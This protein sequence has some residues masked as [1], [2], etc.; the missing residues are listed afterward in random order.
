MPAVPFL[1][2]TTSQSL[3]PPHAH[4]NTDYDML[5]CVMFSAETGAGAL[6]THLYLLSFF[7]GGDKDA[8]ERTD[9]PSYNK[10]TTA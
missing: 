1:T 3:S 5:S 10:K 2:I 9:K 8:S 6:E 4:H 7:Q